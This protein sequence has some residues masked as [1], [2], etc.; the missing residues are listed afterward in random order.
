M[1]KMV[2]AYCVLIIL[3]LASV[4]S[5]RCHRLQLLLCQTRRAPTWYW[6]ALGWCG[7]IDKHSSPEQ[8]RLGAHLIQQVEE[9]FQGAPSKG[10]LKWGDHKLPVLS[11][12][13]NVHD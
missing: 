5:C 6:E 10:L 4:L 2:I 13:A 1:R 8:H 3:Q 12:H 7:E 11:D 9:A